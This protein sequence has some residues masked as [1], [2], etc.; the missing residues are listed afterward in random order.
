MVGI[1]FFDVGLKLFFYFLQER[2]WNRGG[3]G[4]ALRADGRLS[5]I[6]SGLS[7]IEAA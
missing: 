1:G 2:T 4:R 3:F 6:L 5:S 7:D